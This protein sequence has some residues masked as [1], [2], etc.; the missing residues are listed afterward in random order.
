VKLTA[1]PAPG[2][3]F[4]G[5]SGA[6]SGSA[7]PATL[8][9]NI[10][11]AVTATFTVNTGVIH[12]ETQTGASSG[13]AQVA[14]ATSLTGVN[15][16]LYLAAIATKSKVAVTAVSGLGL[17]WT[18]VKAQCSGRD[19]TGIEVWKAQ[20]TPSGNGLVTATLASAPNNAVIA[21][22]RYSGAAAANPIGNIVS[23]NTN[24]ADGACAAGVDTNLYSFNLTTTV[25]G[26]V[27]YGA[28]TMR[29]R[30][31]TPGAGY[32]ERADLKQGS[33]NGSMASVAVQDRS[34]ASAATVAVNGTLSGDVD[35]AVV[36]LEIK[37]Q[38]ASKRGEIAGNEKSDA[39]PSVYQL[40]QNY[41]NPFNP[42]TMINFAL[43]AAGKVVVRIYS[44][45]GQLVNTL[46]N[47][48]MAA[49]RHTVR[50]N[51]RNQLGH[52]VAA[53]IYLYQIVV[54]GVDG[55]AVFTRTQRMTFLK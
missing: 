6:L 36:G 20:G 4:S 30:T 17:S 1:I 39:F 13:S 19:L 25:N 43:P 9:M 14:T 18:L 52:A 53:G 10:N 45:T 48:E 8:A 5:W 41:P 21:V 54:K 51:G 26:A 44:E 55:N 24:G 50:W 46:V 38:A 33:T 35:W 27:A 28:A 2:F 37:P 34:V 42:S 3:L 40:E 29:S 32:T 16:Q 31:H 12:Q 23:G 49:G 15:G 22:S 7:N 47:G 11:K